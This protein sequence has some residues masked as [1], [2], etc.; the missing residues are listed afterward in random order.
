MNLEGGI[1]FLR[2]V[3]IEDS[4]GLC[5]TFEQEMQTV[6][7]TYQCE[8]KTTVDDEAKSKTF[9]AFVNSD[10][11]DSQIVFVPERDQVRPANKEELKATLDA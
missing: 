2:E 7:D 9:D 11:G 3:V 1:D 8:W 10:K 5:E 6:V 4:L